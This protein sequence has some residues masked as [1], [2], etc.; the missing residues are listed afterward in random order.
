MNPER[1][2]TRI[3][4]QAMRLMTSEAFLRSSRRR[5]RL[6][7]RLSGEAQAVHYFHQVDDPYSHL[8]VQKLDALKAAY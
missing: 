4:S 3:R 8:A 5:A 2:K 1:L 7:R 6:R